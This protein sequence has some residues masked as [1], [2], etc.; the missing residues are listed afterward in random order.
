MIQVR[1][2]GKQNHTIVARTA[3][4]EEEEGLHDFMIKWQREIREERR[5]KE[6]EI[7][8]AQAI[9]LASALS[10]RRL[11]PKIAVWHR[12]KCLRAVERRRK[13]VNTKEK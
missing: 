11:I 13:T 3:L 6:H 4:R 10:L 7:P 5:M 12:A 8:Y 1:F 2:G 9:D